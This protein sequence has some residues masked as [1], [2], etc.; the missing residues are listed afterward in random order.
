MS[1]TID[2]YFTLISPFAYLGHDRLLEIAEKHG[3]SLRF[4]P[5]NLGAVFSQTGG[6][7]LPLR[8]PARQD[9]RWLELQRW[10]EIR[11]LPLNLRPAHFPTDPTLADCSAIFLAQS[12]GR[13]AEFARRAFRACWELDR[14]IADEHVIA[15]ILDDLG[16]HKGDLITAALSENVKEIYAENARQAAAAGVFGSPCYILNGEL[17]WGQDR[18]DLLEAALAS[19]RAPYR[20]I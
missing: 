14:D 10:R 17:F 5:V 6:L 9:Y 20:P 1:A 18:L 8:H 2:Y 11:K 4:F 12:G 16:A 19:G 15:G 7:P 3:A 13:V